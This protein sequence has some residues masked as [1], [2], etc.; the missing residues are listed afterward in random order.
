MYTFSTSNSKDN[1]TLIYP[2][3][4]LELSLKK[5][6]IYKGNLT[7][8]VEPACRISGFLYA[9][10]YRMQ[11][12]KEEF[13]GDTIQLA[14][15]FDA[16]GLEEDD[17]VRGEFYLITDIGEYTLSFEI[18]IA[19]Q[20]IESSIGPVRNLFHFVNLARMNWDEAVNVFYRPEFE[21]IFVGSDRQ[22]KSAYR[23]LCTDKYSE[24]QVEEFLILIRKKQAVSFTIEEPRVVIDEV[25]TK[26]N[27]ICIRRNN[28]GYTKLYLKSDAPFISLVKKQLSNEDFV[29]DK[30]EIIFTIDRT[31]LHAGK[32]Y[33]RIIVEAALEQYNVEIIVNQ[34]GIFS[35]HAGEVRKSK[36]L[37]LQL[38]KE[39]LDY[40]LKQ[41]EPEWFVKADKLINDLLELDSRNIMARLCQ[42]QLLYEQKRDNEAKWILR[43]VD[44]M[45][46]RKM[47]SDNNADSTT[48]LA[49]RLYLE[50]VLA[51]EENKIDETVEKIKRMFCKEPDNFT[52]LYS[53]M[54]LDNGMKIN[55]SLRLQEMQQLFYRGNHSPFLY[56]EAFL[57]YDKMPSR[58]NELGIFEIQVLLFAT[59]YYMLTGDMIRQINHL[60]LRNRQLT[61]PLYKLLGECCQWD[62]TTETLQTI[63]TLLIKNEKT[64]KQYFEWYER[65]VKEELRITRLY[66]Y[67]LMSADLKN[68]EL[69]PRIVLMYFSYQCELDYV[70]KAYLYANILRH[71]EEIPELYQSYAEQIE[72]FIFNQV[73]LGHI[74]DDLAYLYKNIISERMIDDAFARE[75]VKLLFVRKVTVENKSIKYV[76]LIEEKRCVEK[77]VPVTD[78][79]SYV[80]VYDEEFAVLLEKADGKRYAV[81]IPFTQKKLLSRQIFWKLV[82]EYVETDSGACLY[83]CQ[84]HTDLKQLNHCQRAFF[85][86]LYRNT[87]FIGSFRRQIGMQ[88]MQYYFDADQTSNL[89][90]LLEETELTGL[91]QS[92]RAQVIRFFILRDMNEK[93]Y[94]ALMTYGF[95][96]V[97]NKQLKQMFYYGLSKFNGERNVQVLAIANYIFAMAKQDEGVLEYLVA[98]FEGN[99][100]QM[101][102]IWEKAVECKLDA[103]ALAEKILVQMLFTGAYVAHKHEIFK[104][105]YEAGA[106]PK[107]V[108]EYLS[109]CAYRYFVEE[110]VVDESIFDI[111]LKEEK[112]SSICKIATIQFFANDPVNMDDNQKEVVCKYMKELL[113]E[114]IYFPFFNTVANELPILLPRTERTYVEYRTKRGVKVILHYVLGDN[115]ELSEYHKE[116]MREVYDGYYCKSFVLFFGEKLQYYITEEIDGTEMLTKSNTVEKSDTIDLNEESRFDLLNQMIMSLSLDEQES[117]K[118]L[119]IDY[120]RRDFVTDKLFKIR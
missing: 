40:R 87:D 7:F 93:A 8:A 56:L 89:D 117:A 46:E 67:Y 113:A 79:V 109:Y 53:L 120:A 57:L 91:N 106:N 84:K 5:D 71:A 97:S 115:E 69:L 25:D 9:S 6:E 98:N 75:F 52:C 101:R 29:S 61:K 62:E 35:R 42:A 30:A 47:I 111:I 86:H 99:I 88:L 36:Q 95:E 49:Y 50:A 63:C 77:K 41:N 4:K 66:E 14:Y 27:S 70:H 23:G 82:E 85:V 10:H 118:E 105:Y 83:F 68:E 54:R 80:P 96:G 76:V 28:W 45:L 3:S 20:I 60:A 32:N 92:E 15:S 1:H 119:A 73:N 116:E 103:R 104:Y 19:K 51:N 64:G 16:T 65:A 110:E 44:D 37:M 12:E 26:V 112:T 102:S 90:Q 39:Y 114:N 58:L 17:V 18:T 2:L 108:S 107:V 81:S 94:Q 48:I 33:G 21:K 78:G 38:V 13:E 59:K 31:K 11:C 43:H 55:P 22:Y 24:A 34:T 74:N 100:K 72:H